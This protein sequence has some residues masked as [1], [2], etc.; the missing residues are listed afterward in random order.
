MGS[1]IQ[2]EYFGLNSRKEKNSLNV[3]VTTI[4]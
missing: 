2:D 1:L 3:K 4:P